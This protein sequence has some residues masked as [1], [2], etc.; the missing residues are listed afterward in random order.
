MAAWQCFSLRHG[1][2]ESSAQDEGPLCAMHTAAVAL[3]RSG[4]PLGL[5]Q[6]QLGHEHITTTML[7]AQFH[8]EY[9]ETAKYFEQVGE[10]F[11]LNSAG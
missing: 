3:A 4:M 7:Y 6:R 8:P 9:S 5:L 1:V 11:G 10:H 2:I